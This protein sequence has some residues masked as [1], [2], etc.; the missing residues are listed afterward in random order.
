MWL[1]LVSNSKI[2]HDRHR[3]CFTLSLGGLET[4]VLRYEFTG[5]REVNLLTTQVPVAFRGKGVA[6]LLAKSAL[7]F[8][9]EENLRAHISCW[10]I[11][12]YITENP[13]SEYKDKIVT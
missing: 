8:V 4:A 13:M 10:Y 6:A 3:K 12:Q 1:S 5:D 2:E 7:D 11:K 9:V